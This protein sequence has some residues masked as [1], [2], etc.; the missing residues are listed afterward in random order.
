VTSLVQPVLFLFV[1]GTG[2][3]SLAGH[4]L[5]RAPA[6]R[7]LVA[8]VSRS[9]I[10]VGTCLG[11]ATV[12]QG[13]HPDAGHAAVLPVR[14]ALPAERPADL[15]DRADPVRSADVHRVPDAARGRQPPA[16][17]ACGGVL[18]GAN[19]TRAGWQVPVGLSPGM[20]AVMGAA[21]LGIASAEFQK[22]EW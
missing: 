4:G 22:T 20:A 16:G 11:G 7:R 6:S 5:P 14:G 21:L 19:V 9:A 15:A 18:P 13:A 1:L 10:V 8:P 2:L 17:V 12:V 3:S